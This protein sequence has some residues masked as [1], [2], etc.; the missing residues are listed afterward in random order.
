MGSSPLSNAVRWQIIGMQEAD[1][2]LRQIVQR[3]GRHHSTVGRTVNKH[4][5]TDDVK[6]RDQEGLVLH[7]DERAMPLDG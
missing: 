7:P 3:V 1:M 4:R 5:L 6:D 2:S